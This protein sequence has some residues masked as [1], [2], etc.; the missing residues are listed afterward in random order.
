MLKRVQARM[1]GGKRPP[2][3]AAPCSGGIRSCLSVDIFSLD[4]WIDNGS[5][6]VL[7]V[8]FIQLFLDVIVSNHNIS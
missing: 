6:C 1:G 2:G 7:L 5:Y 8:I 4:E 3:G